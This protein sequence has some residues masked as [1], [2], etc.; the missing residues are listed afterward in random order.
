MW[1]GGERGD[2]LHQLFSLGRNRAGKLLRLQEVLVLS[3]ARGRAWDG[4][5]AQSCPRIP[6]LARPGLDSQAVSGL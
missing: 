5:H 3:R 6:R 1:G 2:Q 4:A